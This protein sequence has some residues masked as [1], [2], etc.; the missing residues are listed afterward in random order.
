MRLIKQ[1]IQK[2]MEL[3]EEFKLKRFY[4]RSIWKFYC[5]LNLSLSFM[6]K[7]LNYEEIR[8]RNILFKKI[9]LMEHI[10]ENQFRYIEKMINQDSHYVL[11]CLEILDNVQNEK[12]QMGD[13][14][15]PGMI[16]VSSFEFEI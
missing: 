10:E 8:R 16:A 13:I 4:K 2:E 14:Y 5:A 1:M 3:Y 11:E 15:I 7:E 6:N 9:L 12:Y